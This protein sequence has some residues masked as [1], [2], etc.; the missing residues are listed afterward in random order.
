MNDK[1]MTKK[2][3][4]DL[5]IAYSKKTSYED[6]KKITMHYEKTD[7]IEFFRKSISRI[8]KQI[9]DLMSSKEDHTGYTIHEWN[10]D[11][12][13]AKTQIGLLEKLIK[14]DQPKIDEILKANK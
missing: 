12:F 11:I 2:R 13:Q 4:A 1:T 8:Q 7:R 14:I 9:K 5:T 6:M 10:K 3:R